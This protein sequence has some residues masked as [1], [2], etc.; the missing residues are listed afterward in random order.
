MIS[1]ALE[2]LA[3][4]TSDVGCGVSCLSSQQVHP[5]LTGSLNKPHEGHDAFE[6]SLDW[7][8]EHFNWTQSLAPIIQ[9]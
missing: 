6:L 3:G 4:R 5:S 2:H 8:N 9:G 7:L 1:A